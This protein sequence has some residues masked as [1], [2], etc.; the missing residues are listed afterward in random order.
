MI[1]QLPPAAVP[2]GALQVPGDVADTENGDAVRPKVRPAAPAAAGGVVGM[3][4]SAAA[5]VLFTVNVSVVLVTPTGTEP[6]FN[7]PPV[8]LAV[9]PKAAAATKRRTPTICT[10]ILNIEFLK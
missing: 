2:A 5:P 1:V 6:K 4:S 3:V 8:T 9:W 10:G 7:G